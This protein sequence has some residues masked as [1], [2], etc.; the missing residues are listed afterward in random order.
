MCHYSVSIQT[1]RVDHISLQHPQL[2]RQALIPSVTL[3]QEKSFICMDN[4]FFHKMKKK[5]VQIKFSL[6]KKIVCCDCYLWYQ[7][8]IS[9]Q[10]LSS[11]RSLSYYVESFAQI[12]FK[13]NIFSH[14]LR[15]SRHIFVLYVLVSRNESWKK[16]RKIFYKLKLLGSTR[17]TG[18]S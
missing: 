11:K 3:G 1:F 12:L 2:L 18:T 5:F 9:T 15:R 13:V 16:N 7:R 6:V 10:H 8:T 14:C 17:F 4:I